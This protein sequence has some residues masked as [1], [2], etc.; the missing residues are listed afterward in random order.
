MLQSE[1]IRESRGVFFICQN[2]RGCGSGPDPCTQFP[3][4]FLPQD[5]SWTPIPNFLENKNRAVG[6]LAPGLRQ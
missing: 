6:L 1:T 4:K 5:F 3:K 2:T